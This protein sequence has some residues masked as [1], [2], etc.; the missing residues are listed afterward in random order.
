MDQATFMNTDVFFEENYSHVSRR[1]IKDTGIPIDFKI[2]FFVASDNYL[3]S[4]E[5][6][7]CFSYIRY[8]VDRDEKDDLVHEV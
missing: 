3:Q 7:E 4:G 6:I 1:D 5:F 2:T 8:V